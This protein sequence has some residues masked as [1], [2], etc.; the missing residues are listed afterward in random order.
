MN[1]GR[2]TVKLLSNLNLIPKGQCVVPN[3]IS[4][5]GWAGWLPIIN[6]IA[7]PQISNCIGKDLTKQETIEH[8][9]INGEEQWFWNF[10]L[11]EYE[12]SISNDSQQFQMFDARERSIK[13]RLERNG[14][15]YPNDMQDVINLFIS[16]GFIT[17]YL[18]E[19]KKL[20][21]DL[22]IRPVPNVK[23][24]LKNM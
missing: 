24:I 23:S 20:Q 17:E 12:N 2:I 10:E 18:D 13:E 5:N 7:L 9:Q 21:I 1:Q 22:L 15:S 8:L 14:L 4:E 19:D 3:N 11:N 6:L 16:L